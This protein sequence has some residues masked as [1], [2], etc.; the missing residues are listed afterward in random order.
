MQRTEERQSTQLHAA[1]AAPP[2]EPPSAPPAAAPTQVFRDR[3][4]LEVLGEDDAV[5]SFQRKNSEE[6]M[7]LDNATGSDEE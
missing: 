7:M 6:Q 3:V 4:G 1:P 2:A 5:V